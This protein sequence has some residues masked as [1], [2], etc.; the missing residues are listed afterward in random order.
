MSRSADRGGDRAPRSAFACANEKRS[1]GTEVSAAGAP[2]LWAFRIVDL[3]GPW[4]WS[5]LG[6]AALREVLQR[7]K[8]LESM[9]WAAIEN[10]TGSHF[11]DDLGGLCKR[12]RDRL[13]EIRQDD[14]AAL[15]SLRISGKRRVW[16]IRDAHV[17]RVLWWD[18][19][20]EVY[21]SQKRHT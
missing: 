20:H 12:A 14:T 19:E 7:L 15:F 3:G 21:P 8:E 5:A 11:I 10:G 4:C 13:V 17:L 9:T 6:G 18:P 2:P 1:R 16:G